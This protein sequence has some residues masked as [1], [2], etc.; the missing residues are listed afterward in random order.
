V[1]KLGEVQT[2]NA[3]ELRRFSRKRIDCQDLQEGIAK[4]RGSSDHGR[5]TWELTCRHM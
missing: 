5:A 4:Y 3:L 1:N 2:G